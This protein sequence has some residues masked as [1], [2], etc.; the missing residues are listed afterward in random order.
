MKA[1]EEGNRPVEKSAKRILVTGCPIGGVL[2]KVVN[3][4]ENNGGAV[5]CFE[6]CGGIK[7]VRSLV[8]ENSDDIVKAIADRYLNIGCSIMSPNLKRTEMLSDLLKEFRI[9]GVIEVVLQA[10]HTYNVE[11]RAVKKLVNDA[12]LPYMAL[13]TDY[14]KSDLGQIKTRISAFIEM[15]S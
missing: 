5:V 12:G 9:E 15:I 6:N 2:D 13:E 4:I 14:S 10:C 8:D 11:T 1:Y 7:P 3:S